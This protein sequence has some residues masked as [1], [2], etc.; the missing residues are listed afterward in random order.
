MLWGEQHIFE[1]TSYTLL[2]DIDVTAPKDY[3][4]SNAPARYTSPGV[5]IAA[6]KINF[7]LFI[8]P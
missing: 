1:I 7:N 2:A 3:Y 4:E 8:S 5:D 6:K